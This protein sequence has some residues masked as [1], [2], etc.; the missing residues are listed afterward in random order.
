MRQTQ[1]KARWTLFA[2]CGRGAF[3]HNLMP[4]Q[5]I[6]ILS[7]ECLLMSGACVSTL[8]HAGLRRKLRAIISIAFVTIESLS[9]LS[10]QFRYLFAG[11]WVQML[12][13]QVPRLAKGQE[14][15]VEMSKR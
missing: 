7:P 3:W 10:E 15:L 1:N 4:D 5:K 12:R 6:G 13:C 14:S 9:A 8:C 11:R 2:A